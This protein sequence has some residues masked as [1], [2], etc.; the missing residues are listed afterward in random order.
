ME[1]ITVQSA[2]SENYVDSPK[3]SAKLFAFCLIAVLFLAGS[4]ARIDNLVKSNAQNHFV[5]GIRNATKCYSRQYKMD[6]TG[7]ASIAEGYLIQEDVIRYGLQTN[8]VVVDVSKATTGFYSLLHGNTMVPIEELKS[9]NIHMV[10]I[11]TVYNEVPSSGNLSVTYIVKVFDPNGNVTFSSS[12]DTLLGVQ[13]Y[14]ESSLGVATDLET[15]IIK[16]IHR[17]QTYEREGATGNNDKTYSTYNTYMCIGKNVPLHGNLT[18]G[19]IDFC[20]LQTYS[21]SR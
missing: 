15:S 20:E 18:T 13:Q 1:L 12:S 5:R 9:Y 19:N 10:H 4:M 17:E 21:T 3:Q 11:Y 16:S 8:P 14:V 6:D 7:L 2:S